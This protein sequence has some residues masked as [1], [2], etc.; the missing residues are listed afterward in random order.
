M[1]RPERGEP[2]GYAPWG[3]LREKGNGL[4]CWVHVV[5][6]PHKTARRGGESFKK[7]ES[8]YR[9]CSTYTHRQCNCLHSGNVPG[10]SKSRSDWA[11]PYR[12]HTCSICAYAVVVG[13]QK[14][15]K[16]E[17]KVPR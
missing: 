2:R 3:G 4:Q 10:I 16:L 9:R 11:S 13:S 1:E 5:R 15:S 7:H 17:Q 8:W 14:H 12:N 6:V